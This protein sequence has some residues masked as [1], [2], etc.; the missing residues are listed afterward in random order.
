MSLEK[1][2]SQHF[3]SVFQR[4]DASNDYAGLVVAAVVIRVYVY[5]M[6]I[7]RLRSDSSASDCAAV[8]PVCHTGHAYSNIGRTTDV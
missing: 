5:M 8:N 3:S 1:S 2:L 4:V 6:R 7:A